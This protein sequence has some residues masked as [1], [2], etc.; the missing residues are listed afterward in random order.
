MS[1]CSDF[2]KSGNKNNLFYNSRKGA[3]INFSG[4]E[5]V[6]VSHN[7]YYGPSEKP[8][9]YQ[10]KDPDNRVTNFECNFDDWKARMT[11]DKSVFLQPTFLDPKSAALKDGQA[12]NVGEPMEE[13]A[14]DITDLPRSKEHPTVGAYEYVNDYDKELKL[15]EPTVVATTENSATISFVAERSSKLYYQAVKA[16][17]E[18]PT[19]EALLAL[20]PIT[21]IAGTKEEIVLNELE[22]NTQYKLYGVLKALS[23]DKT[24]ELITIIP[25]ETPELPTQPASFDD[26]KNYQEGKPFADGTMQFTGFAVAK[27][28]T[29][30]VA[31]RADGTKGEVL[32]T[33]TTKGLLIKS[34]LIRGKGEVVL[35]TDLAKSESSNLPTTKILYL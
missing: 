6:K 34:M 28:G 14:T 1:S 18:A 35:T 10:Y 32:L 25:F 24:S 22:A 20:D 30:G 19:K 4:Q 11:D 9:V 8:F 21:C 17:E 2:K 27:E 23:E 7:G 16:T 13:V 5:I 3:I 15:K 26:V 29:N 31:T 12:F 33:N